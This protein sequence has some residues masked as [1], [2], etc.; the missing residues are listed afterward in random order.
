MFALE[1]IIDEVIA[2]V[3]EEPSSVTIC[4]VGVETFSANEAVI[5]Y[6]AVKSFIIPWGALKY[7]A[8]A[9]FLNIKSPVLSEPDITANE[10]DP[11]NNLSLVSPDPDAAT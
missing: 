9:E 6:D 8:E 5:A 3:V 10:P 1:L 4:S 7:C 2:V 11:I